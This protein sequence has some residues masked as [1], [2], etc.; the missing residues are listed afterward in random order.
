[1]SLPKIT[2]LEA[3]EILLSSWNEPSAQIIISCFR[4][5]GISESSQQLGNVELMI[6]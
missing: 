3:M 6:F 2:I 4:R 5:T 1:M